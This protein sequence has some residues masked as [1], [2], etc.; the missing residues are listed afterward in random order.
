MGKP[1]K[2]Q[3]EE[4]LQC[5]VLELRHVFANGVVVVLA[6]GPGSSQLMH[7]RTAYGTIKGNGHLYP[8]Q[9]FRGQLN[10]RDTVRFGPGMAR[11]RSYPER[12]RYVGPVLYRGMEVVPSSIIRSLIRGLLH[13]FLP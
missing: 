13:P 3:V 9:R 2:E 11:F 7:E 10:D 5:L 12:F 8:L 4:V 1:S 6:L